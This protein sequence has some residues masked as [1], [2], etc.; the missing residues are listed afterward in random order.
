M[1]LLKLLP[2]RAVFG[3]SGLRGTVRRRALRDVTAGRTI[4]AGERIRTVDPNLGKVKT[5]YFLPMS[6]NSSNVSGM[7][8]TDF[9]RIFHIAGMFGGSWVLVSAGTPVVPR[10]LV[11]PSER[12]VG[13]CG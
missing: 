8:L 11:K 5:A 9:I 1:L 12:L 13:A 6:W 2:I 4:G 3:A 7:I 10:P